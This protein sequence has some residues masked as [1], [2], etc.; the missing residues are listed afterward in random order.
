MIFYAQKH[1]PKCIEYFEQMLIFYSKV[2]KKARI[3]RFKINYANHT[4]CS[5]AI[6]TGNHFHHL[7]EVTKLLVMKQLC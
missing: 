3:V 2:F 5:K 6:Q 7:R 1:F 4:F